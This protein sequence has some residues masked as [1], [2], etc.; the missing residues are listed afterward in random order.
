MKKTKIFIFI[1]L[2]TAFSVFGQEKE[3]QVIDEVIAVIGDQIVTKSEIETQMLEYKFPDAESKKLA[4]CEV[5]KQ[6]I[7]QKLLLNQAYIDSI[8]VSDDEIDDEIE[9]RLEYFIMQIGSKEKLEEYYDKSVAEIKEEMWE[10]IK[11]QKMVQ[12]MKAEILKNIQVSPKEVKKFFND[13]PND[14]LPYYNTEVEV[15]Q[16]VIFPEPVKEEK[17]NAR[18]KLLELRKRVLNGEDFGSLAVL[19]SEDEGSALNGG[20]L[21]MRS[22]REF[23]P[24]FSA[25]AMKL[26]KDSISGIVE[27]Q[28]GFHLL[29]LKERK[30]EMIDV[31]HILI[32]PKVTYQSKQDAQ[33]KLNKIRKDILMDTMSFEEATFKFSEDESTKNSGGNILDPE[34]SGIKLS[35]DKLEPSLFFVVDT[36][37]VGTLSKAIP[38]NFQDGRTGYRIVFLK[39]K[40]PPHVANL[41]DDYPKI[42]EMAETYKKAL[43]LQEWVDGAMKRTYITIKE[44]YSNCTELQNQLKEN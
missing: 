39:S 35:V 23:V 42:K 32:K 43:K 17:E 2:A 1:I 36:M 20:C 3:Y 21:G 44:P 12:G 38:V 4:T 14:S 18:K 7:Y 24:E 37:K 9:R 13:I 29:K 25:A 11:E 6:T 16:I 22:K 27:T 15:A 28:Y 26:P 30:G 10:P 8:E 19:Y 41:K 33:E 34:S 40:T 5:A 31:C